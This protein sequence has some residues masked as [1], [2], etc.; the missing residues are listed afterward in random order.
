MNDLNRKVAEALGWEVFESTYS[1][2]YTGKFAV[3]YLRNPEGALVIASDGLPKSTE[4]E[5]WEDVP[6]WLD[7]NKA[8]ELVAG[9]RFRL[10]CEPGGHP[11]YGDD[12]WLAQILEDV[13]ITGIGIADTPTEAICRAWLAWMEAQEKA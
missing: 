6:D 2:E 12:P 5:A 1:T 3:F 4:G 7:M 11:D 10:W 9:M 13:R 8:L